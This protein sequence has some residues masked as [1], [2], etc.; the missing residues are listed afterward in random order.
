MGTLE[1]KDTTQLRRVLVA[2]NRCLYGRDHNMRR[3]ALASMHQ[4]LDGRP[5]PGYRWVPLQ[6]RRAQKQRLRR[7]TFWLGAVAFVVLISLAATWLLGVLDPNSFLV[8][9]LAVLAGIIAIAAAITQV[10]SRTWHDLWE[11]S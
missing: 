9:F 5:I 8:R 7:I 3:E 2:L 10:L 4:L 6:K 1:I 11:R